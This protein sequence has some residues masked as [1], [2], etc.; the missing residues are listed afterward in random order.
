MATH[1]AEDAKKYFINKDMHVKLL[2]W[3]GAIDSNAIEL[4]FSDARAN[5]RKIWISNMMRSIK[6]GPEVSFISYPDVYYCL[7]C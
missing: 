6:F 4:A 7:K 5:D 3:R 2:K 1:D